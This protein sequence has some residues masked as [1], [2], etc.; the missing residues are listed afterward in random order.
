MKTIV[1]LAAWLMMATAASAE[2]KV[3]TDFEGGSAVVESI[4][5][6]TRTIRVTPGGDGK[7]GW[8]CWW[9]LRVDG[10]KSGEVVTIDLGPSTS[11]IQTGKAIAAA[12]S[13]PERASVSHNDVS[14]AQTAPGVKQDGR[15]TY[16]H[17]AEG[18]S[19]WFAWGP[20]FVVSDAEK[21]VKKLEASSADAKAF[22]LTKS[23]EGRP[24][25]AVRIHQKV[26]S[27]DPPY[28]VWIQA[29]QHAWESGASWVCRGLAEWLVSNDVRALAI[30]QTCDVTIVPIMDVDNVATGNGG[31]EEQ[32]Q[33]HN[34]DWTG[35]P[36]WPAVTEAQQRI[37]ALHKS[38]GFDFYLD[39]H[40]PSAGDKRPYYYISPEETMPALEARN[41]ERWKWALD[42]E[43]KSPLKIDA[44]RPVGPKYDKLWE[45]ISHVWVERHTSPWVIGIGF[46]TPWNTTT[47]TPVGYMTIGKQ[48]GLAM[49]KY[50]RSNP[51]K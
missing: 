20:P 45:Q 17:E 31:K 21:L 10:V 13:Q 37:L 7:R 15:I 34:R 12:W 47:S 29:R 23:R 18:G 27:V 1:S 50:F 46:E 22:V 42:D 3:S 24:V 28:G 40:N 35:S 30:R 32:P 39:L 33:D 14:W 48:L 25:W 8:P 4:D 51:R 16:K 6:A 38:T 49:E 19:I 2:L 11:L 26:E 36:H 43:M 5:Q 9:Y 44:A 41:M